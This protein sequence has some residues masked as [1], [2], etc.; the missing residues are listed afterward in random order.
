MTLTF[1]GSGSAF[2]L[3]EENYQS[4]ILIEKE[5]VGPVLD[6]NGDETGETEN[7]IG[8]ILFDAGTTIPEALNYFGYEVT[9]IDGIILSHLHADHCGGLE[10]LGFKTYFIPEFGTNKPKLISNPKVLTALWENTL[11]GT[12][13]SLR[14][15][16]AK[17]DT[18]F[19]VLPVK[20]R[21]SFYFANTEY[22]LTQV[23]HVVDDME[24]VPAFG[25]KFVEDNTKVFITGDTMFDFWKHIGNYE[26]ADVIFH[27]CEFKEYPNSVH[28]QFHQLKTLP[29]Q[30]KKKM[31][32]YHYML[33]G[34]TFEELEKE[35]LEAG[36]AGLVKR[37]Q[38][39]DTKVMKEELNG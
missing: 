20:P 25:L 6:E 27:D 18:F 22:F 24:E 9:D 33:D 23:P 37:G 2:V 16:R 19:S 7:R 26:W 34:K 36:F 29:E 14:G 1:F 35:V 15:E 12:M 32:L 4:N 13:G 3:A 17:L 10:Y 21:E 11:K 8:R 31:Y 28:A 38:Q 5:W 39:F 30:Y